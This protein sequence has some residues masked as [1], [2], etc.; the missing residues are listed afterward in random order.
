MSHFVN[1][2][3]NAGDEPPEGAYAFIQWKGTDAC[4]DFTCDCG[5]EAHFDGYFAYVVKCGACGQE[6]EMPSLLTPRKVCADTYPQE[7][8][9]LEMDDEE[10]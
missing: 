3:P 1:H 5:A 6:W 10:G 2:G 4:F 9:L 8:K 7:A